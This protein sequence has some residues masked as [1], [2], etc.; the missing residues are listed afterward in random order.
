[1]SS[2][3]VSSA[4]YIRTSRKFPTQDKELQIELDKSYIDVASAINKRTIGIFP[5]NREAITGESWYVS[6]KGRQQSI[7][8]VYDFTSATTF[9][10]PHQLDYDSIERFVRLFG[11]YTD[12]ANNWYGIIGG[13]SVA[14]AGQISFYITPTNLVFLTGAGAPVMTR[15]SVVIEWL[16]NV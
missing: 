10:I 4:P 3:F 13:T 5:I 1:M 8:R 9:P 14:I 11:T 6:N 2:N 15:G 16:S 7:R 12:A